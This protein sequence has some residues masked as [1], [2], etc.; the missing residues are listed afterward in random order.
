MHCY[1][2]RSDLG[3]PL[4]VLDGLL[5]ATQLVTGEGMVRVTS[6]ERSG[7]RSELVAWLLQPADRSVST[8]LTV[9]AVD[10]AEMTMAGGPGVLSM[11]C[12]KAEGTGT[13]VTSS[14][15]TSSSSQTARG[16]RLP[17]SATG[18]EGTGVLLS[19]TVCLGMRNRWFMEGGLLKS[20]NVRLLFSSLRA[21]FLSSLRLLLFAA[22][23]SL[24]WFERFDCWLRRVSRAL[25]S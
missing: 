23:L 14:S 15:K 22:G 21:S 12:S 19:I 20:P 24:D 17:L 25:V 11:V 13:I 3:D 18:G 16:G 4:V 7:L 2:S 1:I 9:F 5:F 10:E 8:V 6:G